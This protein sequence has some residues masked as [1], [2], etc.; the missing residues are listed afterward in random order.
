MQETNIYLRVAGAP[1]A[2]PAHNWQ[3]GHQGESEE[4][5]R[6]D[7]LP[8]TARLAI[9]FFVLFNAPV[10]VTDNIIQCLVARQW[11]N[12]AHCHFSAYFCVP[13][14]CILHLINNLCN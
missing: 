12:T 1:G 7:P 4:N 3:A 11:Y 10:V 8:D 13:V 14:R 6:A 2:G 9:N 5:G